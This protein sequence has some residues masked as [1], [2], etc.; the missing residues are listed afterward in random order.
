[1]P[2]AELVKEKNAEKDI[3]DFYDLPR[4]ITLDEMLGW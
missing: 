2:W 4:I 1:M 3:K